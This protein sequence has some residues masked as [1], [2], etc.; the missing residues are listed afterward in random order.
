[1]NGRDQTI[2]QQESKL[3]EQELKAQTH[4]DIAVSFMEE[5]DED[6]HDDNNEGQSSS[7]MIYDMIRCEKDKV[8]QLDI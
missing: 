7:K 2:K 5:L 4:H 8:L 6:E 3:A 1:M